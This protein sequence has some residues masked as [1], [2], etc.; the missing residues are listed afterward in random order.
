M[1]QGGQIPT[2]RKKRIKNVVSFTT[3]SYEPTM[4][5]KF[6][7]AYYEKAILCPFSKNCALS[8]LS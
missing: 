5:S 1:V 6:E 3:L 4:S 8:L 2:K 7:D